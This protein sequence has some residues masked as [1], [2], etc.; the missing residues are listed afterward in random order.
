M[1]IAC[2]TVVAV[3]ILHYGIPALERQRDYELKERELAQ[4]ERSLNVIVIAPNGEK[5]ALVLR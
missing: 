2:L 1:R 5:H 4:T 3:A